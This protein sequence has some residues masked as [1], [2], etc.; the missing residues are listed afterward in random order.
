MILQ[1]SDRQGNNFMENLEDSMVLFCFPQ[2]FFHRKKT[3]EMLAVNGVTL[4]C[5]ESPILL[6]MKHT[7]EVPG[8]CKP[9]WASAQLLTKSAGTSPPNA[10]HTRKDSGSYRETLSR[11]R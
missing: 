11:G 8:L 6:E 5:G 9:N 10:S 1:N 2:K 7:Q 4:N 3:T